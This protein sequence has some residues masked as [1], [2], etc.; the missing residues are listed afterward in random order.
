[1]VKANKFKQPYWHHKFQAKVRGI[2]FLLT[3]D[4]W[5]KFW[6]DSGHFHERG[7]CRGKYVMA[8]FGDVGPYA[9]GNIKIISHGENISEGRLGRRHS[10]ETRKKQS[11]SKIGKKHS[12]E[13][14]QKASDGKRGRKHTI[15]AKQK[16][17]AALKGRKK[18]PEHVK[19]MT[20]AL[21]NR[22]KNN[23]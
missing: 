17:S 13:H 7:A 10:D 12:P 22:K 2:E 21:L 16:I 4:E 18:S 19:N 9:L 8:R 11:L 15:E 1:M 20:L 6:I 23:G 3:F 14:I 5:F